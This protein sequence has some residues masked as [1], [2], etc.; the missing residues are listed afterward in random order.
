M[1][2]QE[3]KDPELA[4]LDTNK[5]LA[6][7]EE[8]SRKF[9]NNNSR[10]LD[11]I[12]SQIHNIQS[13]GQNT[14]VPTSPPTTPPVSSTNEYVPPTGEKEHI[15]PTGEKTDSAT[16]SLL[17][18]ICNKVEAKETYNQKDYS[19]GKKL[20]FM[21][22][23][24][25]GITSGLGKS[26]IMQSPWTKAV[27]FLLSGPGILL[28]F[29]VYKL[30]MKYVWNGPIGTWIKNTID[31]IK[32]FWDGTKEFRDWI[33]SNLPTMKQIGNAFSTLFANITSAGGF[34]NKVGNFLLDSGQLINILFGPITNPIREFVISLLTNMASLYDKLGMK[35]F[36]ASTMGS[37]QTLTSGMVGDN[38]SIQQAKVR[39]SE[40]GKT[41][42][43]ITDPTVAAL[44]NK[45]MRDGGHKPT[46][47]EK[48][49]LE[50]NWYKREYGDAFLNQQEQNV[51]NLF[52]Y[53]QQIRERYSNDTSQFSGKLSEGIKSEIVREYG[54]ADWNKARWERDRL[55]A[56]KITTA[57][58]LNPFLSELLDPNGPISKS[59]AGQTLLL[60]KIIEI[61]QTIVGKHDQ[62][63]KQIN[64]IKE[65]IK[66][67]Q[68]N[69]YNTLDYATESAAL[70]SLH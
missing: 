37:V 63:D 9:Y 43:A 20:P 56:S 66:G 6:K 61:S 70:N 31:W 26:I 42:A 49:T 40:I 57:Q 55:A 58:D 41:Y 27:K 47:E 60:N 64:I 62:L 36:A 52:R 17:S 45:K 21:G 35:N 69:I 15:P 25:E 67:N 24:I 14:P 53:R 28:M 4:S 32:G 12:L 46:P 38:A 18:K 54:L 68:V 39:N 8:E 16:K 50:S 11:R 1:A 13:P 51:K 19:T 2:Q 30:F 23:L 48:A 33:T 5:R 3:I 7:F 10:A 22:T 44:L 34:W 59:T 65:Q 29:F